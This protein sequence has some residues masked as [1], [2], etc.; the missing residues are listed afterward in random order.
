MPEKPLEEQRQR[1]DKWLFFARLAK[2]RSL[3]QDLVEAGL[4]E[5]NAHVVVQPGRQVKVGDR[6]AIRLERRDMVLIVRDCADRRG[7]ASSARLL[8][9]DITPQQAPL[10]AFERALRKPLGGR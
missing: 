6:I 4:V 3:A 2:S 7:P 5:I 1:I 9:E 10:S 8:Y